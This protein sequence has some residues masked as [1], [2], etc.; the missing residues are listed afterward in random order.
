MSTW[1]SR[2]VMHR[3]ILSK[4]A[5]HRWTC[6]TYPGV[7]FTDCWCAHVDP[8]PPVSRG[9][10]CTT[11][12]MPSSAPLVKF[13]NQDLAPFLWFFFSFFEYFLLLA[14]W[15]ML[16]ILVQALEVDTAE[17]GSRKGGRGKGRGMQG[18][19]VGEVVRLGGRG[20]GGRDEAWG[21][22]GRGGMEED[23]KEGWRKRRK[24]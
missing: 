10:G 4:D 7:A 8:I 5:T 16:F 14:S 19:Q 13:W 20:V 23:E 11:R 17:E 22:G 18:H 2:W 1:L 15:H 3:A 12:K 21:G 9:R 24:R 6:D